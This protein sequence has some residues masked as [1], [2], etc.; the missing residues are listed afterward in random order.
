MS[1]SET[2]DVVEISGS[3]FKKKKKKFTLRRRYACTHA[4][5]QARAVAFHACM[6]ASRHACMHVWHAA[7]S[8]HSLCLLLLRFTHFVYSCCFSLM[9]AHTICE[10]HKRLSCFVLSG[11][12]LCTLLVATRVPQRFSHKDVRP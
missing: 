4:R 11:E 10:R 9:H 7:V 5:T 8:F 6:H 1:E 2:V 3:T 12:V